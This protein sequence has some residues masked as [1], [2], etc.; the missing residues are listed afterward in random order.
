M[1]QEIGVGAFSV[2]K[3]CIHK[4]TGQEYAVKIIDKSRRDTSEEVEVCL[5]GWLNWEID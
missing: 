1:V 5:F 2:C 4:A 3:R